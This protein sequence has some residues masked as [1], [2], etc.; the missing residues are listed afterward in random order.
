MI[1]QIALFL[2]TRSVIKYRYERPIIYHGARLCRPAFCRL[3]Y[4]SV[5]HESINCL[6]KKQHFVTEVLSRAV[7][8]KKR[9]KAVETQ[10]QS[11]RD[12]QY[13]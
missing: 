4:N 9:Q 13:R 8:Q 5:R 11:H 1:L 2:H 3:L 10:K 7:S 6:Y 12:S